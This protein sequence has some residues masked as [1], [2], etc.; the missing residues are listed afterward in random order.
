VK[1]S[2][3]R[4]AALSAFLLAS[5]GGSARA[6]ELSSHKFPPEKLVEDFRLVRKALEEAHSGVYRYT[7]RAEMDRIFDKAEKSLDRPMDVFE[8]YRVVAP[9]VAAVK[10]GHTGTQL[11]AGLP[12]KPILPLSVRYAGGKVYVFRDLS[13]EIRRLDGMEIRS[14]NDVPAGDIV[15]T[16]LAATSGDGDVQTSR[17]RRAG[18]WSFA[19]RLKSVKGIDAPFDVVLYDGRRKENVSV[20][21][22][23]TDPGT[24]MKDWKE[25][26]P[27][28]QPP[29]EAASLRYEDG[30]AIAVLKINRFGGT[31]GTDRKKPLGEFINE[32]FA[33][34]D[35]KKSSSLILD[36]RNNGGGA[37]ELG[38]LLLAH[39]VDEPFRYYDDLVVNAL[40]FSVRKYAAGSEP[41]PAE[42]FERRPD[43]KYRMVKHPNWGEQKPQKPVFHGKVYA[44]INGGSFSTTCEFLSHL[45]SR[46]RATFVGEE[47]GGG[48][49]GNTSGMGLRVTLPNTKILVGVP[50]MT[51]YLAVPPGHDAKHGV[52]PD[53]AV[54]Y[55]IDELLSGTDKDLEVALKLARGK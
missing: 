40:E 37:D 53:H 17:L 29:A 12:D 3:S 54:S 51:Y 45:H 25:K 13:A 49:Y 15:K 20:L 41:V 28:D 5:L 43:G 52:V 32:A 23:G 31:V 6:D 39:L 22:P 4:F 21:L 47:S 55:T 11:P 34:I 44:L 7:P 24:L 36:L 16:L 42:Y 8:F 9:V 14:I 38:K 50:L 35:A 33:E 18:D 30:G 1:H 46:K 19:R 26:Y 2:L 10:C 48:Y 27:Q